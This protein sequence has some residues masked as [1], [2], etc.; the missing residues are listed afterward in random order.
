MGWQADASPT[1]SNLG[2]DHG[3]WR[4]WHPSAIA[5][6]DRHQEMVLRPGLRENW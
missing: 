6:A 4:S 2:K 3:P 1:G 5:F